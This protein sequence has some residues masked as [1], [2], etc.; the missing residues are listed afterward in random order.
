M[1]TKF[2]PAKKNTR[3]PAICRKG[4][5]GLPP[6]Y[7][8][9]LPTS[10]TCYAAATKTSGYDNIAQSFQLVWEPARARWRGAASETGANIEAT[11]HGVAVD[12]TYELEIFVRDGSS[13]LGTYAWEDHVITPGPPFDS[14]LLRRP[15]VP[16]LA[17]FSIHVM[18]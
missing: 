14:G 10:L 16:P 17:G 13:I 1:S 8:G 11:V 3:P 2:S 5:V 15:P 4:A 6:A 9:G 12:D 18:N 7:V